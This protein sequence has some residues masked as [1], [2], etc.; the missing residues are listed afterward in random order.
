MN[1][2]T[3]NTLEEKKYAAAAILHII[4]MHTAASR[5]EVGS[6]VE[7]CPLGLFFV[8]LLNEDYQYLQ[9]FLCILCIIMLL[10]SSYSVFFKPEQN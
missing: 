9:V 10:C 4:L 8:L 6:I 1:F 3:K 5:H 7:L 2:D